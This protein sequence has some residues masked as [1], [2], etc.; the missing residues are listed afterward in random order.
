MKKY[1]KKIS[2]LLMAA[3]MVLTMCATVFAAAVSDKNT[4][5][6]TI[7]GLNTD[8]TPTVRLYKV[9]K[10]NYSEQGF[11]GT[12][13]NANGVAITDLNNPTEAE[14]NAI[15]QGIA[16]GTISSYADGTSVEEVTAT[17]NGD[18]ATA[19][20]TGAG[21]YI[22]LITGA[23]KTVYNPLILA[24]PI[25]KTVSCHMIESVQVIFMPILQLP[26]RHLRRLKKIL[27]AVSKQMVTKL[28]YL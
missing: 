5:T 23:T 15:A 7:T 21:V 20:A 17:V 12:Y 24:Y 4:A 3:I 6:I 28:Q 9:V 10:G 18:T 13:T 16:A 8:E 14:I 19:T 25:I 2:A 1:F 22:A 27:L 26:K 11:L